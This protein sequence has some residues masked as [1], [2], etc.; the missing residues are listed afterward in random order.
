MHTFLVQCTRVKRFDDDRIYVRCFSILMET[1]LE[2]VFTNE[3][4]TQ[5][6][7]SKLKIFDWISSLT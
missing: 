7:D 6:A 5:K 2:A 1:F 3:E 4:S